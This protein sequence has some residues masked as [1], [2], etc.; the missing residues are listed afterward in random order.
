MGWPVAAAA[1][2]LPSLLAEAVGTPL[3]PAVVGTPLYLMFCCIAT[4]G[5]GGVPAAAAKL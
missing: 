2:M 3:P 1:A 4:A 5:L